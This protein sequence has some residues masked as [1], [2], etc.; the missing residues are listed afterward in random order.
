MHRNGSRD[1]DMSVSAALLDWY[2]H[3]GRKDLPW[4]AGPTPYRVWVSEI[5]LQQTQVATVIPYYERFVTRFPAVVD[6]A[7]ASQDQVLH[8]WSG[9]GYYSRA[10]HLHAAAREI[11]TRHAG[12]FPLEF[13]A[14]LALPGIGRSTAGAILALACGQRHPILDGNVKRVLTRYHVVDGWPGRADVQQALWELAERHTPTTRVAEYTQAIMD[15]GATVCTRTR[16]DCPQCPLGAG[17]AARAAGCQTAYPG[18]RVRKPLPV[19]QTILLLAV[20]ERDEV[21]LEKRPP[22]GIWGGLWSFPEAAADADPVVWC[23]ESL[24]MTLREWQAWPVLRHTFSHFHLDITPVQARIA[25]ADNRLMEDGNRLWYNISRQDERGIAAPV[26]KLLKQLSERLAERA[27]HGT[28][29]ALRK[30][31]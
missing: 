25:G 31:G 1:E 19:R 7:R 14:V 27:S 10:R 30:T 26:G 8:Y 29:R 21:L 12:E 24:G 2:A 23:R 15:L 17:C 13:E 20:N 4:Q 22:A 11:V 16:P 9:L 6:L 28:K 18:R 5:M 3:S